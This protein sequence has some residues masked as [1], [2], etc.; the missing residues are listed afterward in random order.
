M[1][2]MGDP[3][4]FS[5][6]QGFKLPPHGLFKRTKCPCVENTAVVQ[7][8]LLP[9]CLPLYIDNES[10]LSF[11]PLFYKWKFVV[12]LYNISKCTI[13]I[14]ILIWCMWIFLTFTFLMKSLRVE[15]ENEYDTMLRLLEIS[16]RAS[17]SQSSVIFSITF[18]LVHYPVTYNEPEPKCDTSKTFEIS[19]IFI[20]T[21]F[22]DSQ[23]CEESTSKSS[24]LNK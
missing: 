4:S 9:P 14:S 1:G 10:S 13:S 16:S 5:C 6:P 19:C 8:P 15:R 7:W 20:W 17:L 18:Y 2:P 24:K 11:K 12:L 21:N 23:N 22:I 3:P